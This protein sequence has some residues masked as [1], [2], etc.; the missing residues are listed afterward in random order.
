MKGN[1]K[2]KKGNSDIFLVEHL[3]FSVI[4]DDDGNQVYNS[5]PKPN[6]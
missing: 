4:S 1:E 2:K 3:S 5:Y 6:T